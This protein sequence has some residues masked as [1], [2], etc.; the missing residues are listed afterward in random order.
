MPM[1]QCNGV[2]SSTEVPSPKYVKLT[3]KVSHDTEDAEVLG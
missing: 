1:D 2:R 3:T